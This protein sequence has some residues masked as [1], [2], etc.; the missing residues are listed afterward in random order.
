MKGLPNSAISRATP[1]CGAGLLGY[2]A[3]T[4]TVPRELGE[5][6]DA[7][8][9]GESRTP[10][11]T[12]CPYRDVLERRIVLIPGLEQTAQ[13]HRFRPPSPRSTIFS[14]PALADDAARAHIGRL[15]AGDERASHFP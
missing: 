14:D 12:S 4:A 13:P 8:T 10:R 1:R 5:V 15:L 11:P 9:G 2:A 3:S 7:A 6:R